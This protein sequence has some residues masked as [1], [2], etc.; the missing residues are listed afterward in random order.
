MTGNLSFTMD[1]IVEKLTVPGY[2]Q[3]QTL[4]YLELMKKDGM[5]L[6]EAIERLRDEQ[7]LFGKP[8][9]IQGT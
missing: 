6:E 1:E 7:A 2:L 4:H 5:T 3:D 9:P 8:E